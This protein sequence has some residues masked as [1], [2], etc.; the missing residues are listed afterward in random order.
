VD[1]GIDSDEEEE[2]YFDIENYSG[3][4]VPDYSGNKSRVSLFI[5]S[6][7]M[8]VGIENEIEIPEEYFM[9][10]N[11]PNPFNPT[12]NIEFGIPESGHV[13]IKV[14]DM[15]GREVATLI[16][17]TMS[18]GVRTVVFDA[19]HLSSGMYIYRIKVNDYVSTKRL[20]LIK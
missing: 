19:S 18:A 4:G 12:T 8:S 20:M 17:N 11:Y 7:H 14:Y 9:N 5:V 1:L 16:N 15:L 10:Q 6:I 3:Y 13:S 2:I